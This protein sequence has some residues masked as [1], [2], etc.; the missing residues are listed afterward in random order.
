MAPEGPPSFLVVGLGNPGRRYERN[1][2]NIGFQCVDHLARQYGIEWRRSRFNA[3]IADLHIGAHRV[4][5]VK[6]LTFMNSSGE[7]VAAVSHWY[8]IPPERILVIYDDLDLPLARIRLRPGGSS[9]GHNGIASIIERLGSAGF[10]RLRIGI[11]RPVH[12]DPTDYVLNDFDRDQEPL[13][14]AVYDV[15]DE[16]VRCVLDKGIREAMNS[17]NGRDIVRTADTS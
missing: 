12:G 6:P 9:G 4:L 10:A 16:I 2:H 5:L 7:A 14:H 17:Y 1:R 3:Q 13:I 11:G 8:K 15:I